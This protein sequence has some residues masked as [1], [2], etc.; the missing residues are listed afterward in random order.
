MEDLAREIIYLAGD[1]DKYRKQVDSL[2]SF[3]DLTSTTRDK[4]NYYTGGTRIFQ[5]KMCE[6]F[7]FGRSDEVCEQYWKKFREFSSGQVEALEWLLERQDFYDFA[8]DYYYERTLC[9]ECMYKDLNTFFEVTDLDWSIECPCCG[10]TNCAK[11]IL[12]ERGAYTFKV[13]SCG[14]RKSFLCGNCYDSKCLECE[15]DCLEE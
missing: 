1:V 15:P 9:P 8:D 14:S 4:N 5:C 13:C 6:E 3:L 11:H 2:V 10:C 12:V 7:I